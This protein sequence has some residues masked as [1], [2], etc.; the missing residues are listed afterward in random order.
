[1]SQFY[2]NPKQCLSYFASGTGAAGPFGYILSLFVL[3]AL[4]INSASFYLKNICSTII[5]QLVVASYLGTFFLIL[6]Q[7]W[8]DQIREAK[9]RDLFK[10]IGDESEAEDLPAAA[11]P[12]ED[13]DME[14]PLLIEDSSS[15]KGEF[16][17]VKSVADTLSAKERFQFITSLWPYMVPLFVVYVSEYA[18]QSGVWTAFA[19]PSSRS[20]VSTRVLEKSYRD[21]AYKILN[22][23]YQVGVF[24]S[25]SSG[26]LFQPNVATL[27]MMPTLQCGLWIFFYA[28]A[29]QH[30]M[31]GYILLLP[32]FVTGLL[33]GAVYVN[34]FTLI[35]KNLLPEY[36]ELALSATAFACDAGILLG[37][38]SGLFCQF[39]LFQSMNIHVD[40]SGTCP[41]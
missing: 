4:T 38:V 11:S 23:T 14:D 34:A 20:Q 7:P 30:F 22:F 10:S 26:L 21:R 15:N 12:P 19:L 24:V 6:E 16:Q 28:I 37:N 33:G 3:P 1:M 39:C 17:K 9:Q 18:M 36:R 29:I 35:D 8:V 2:R 40:D 5:G 25:R 32:A 27:W 13:N 41:F 31:Y